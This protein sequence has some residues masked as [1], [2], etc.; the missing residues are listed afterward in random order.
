MVAARA[1][2]VQ[3]L[4][5]DDQLVQRE[6]IARVVEATGTMCVAGMAN[7]AEKAMDILRQKRIDLALVDLVLGKKRGIAVGRAMR[8]LQPNLKVI[9]YTRERSMVLAAEIFWARK[10]PAR[11]GLQ[12]Y[13]LTRNISSSRY[14]QHVYDQIVRTG[15]YIDREVLEWH[16]KLTEFEPLTPREEECAL[17]VADG[18]SNREIAQR[19]VIS[20]RRV[21]NIVSSL[22]LKFR[23][24]GDPGNPGRRVLLAEAVKLL[25][26][27]RPPRRP[28]SVLLI[29]DKNEQRAYL[30]RKLA[31]DDRL[32]VIAEANS[33][34][35]G[36][37]LVRQKKPDI[38]LVDVHLPDVDGFKV[39][40]Q[41][42]RE[43]PQTKVI[44]NSAARSRTYEEEAH[45]AGAVA[46][47]PK[48]QISA[49]TVY[50][51]CYADF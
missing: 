24:L 6:G 29:D 34:Q 39:T 3:V 28:L 18:F 2:L 48:S 30:L 19:M 1:D 40:R 45:Q 41:I 43:C 10:K 14:I 37:E 5:L 44:M 50:E 35:R 47:I 13:I 36:L 20:H 9:I 21:E 49:A 27:L 15:H 7:T 16:Y 26:S 11:A 12:G 25:Y 42:L 33:G 17:L 22:Y 4:I 46:F 23:I 31:G 51:L 38:V 8:R 32:Q